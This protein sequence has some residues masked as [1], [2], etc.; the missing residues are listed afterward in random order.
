M[1]NTQVEELG[2]SSTKY[3]HSA[4]ISLLRDYHLS[5]KVDGIIIYNISEVRGDD[6]LPVL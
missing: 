6:N 3:F 1:E 4:I 2:Q 5:W